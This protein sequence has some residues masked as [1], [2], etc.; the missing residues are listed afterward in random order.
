MPKPTPIEIQQKL[1][2]GLREATSDARAALKDLARARK[3]VL[4]LIDTVPERVDRE[5]GNMVKAELDNIGK[6][7]GQAIE[8]S[9]KRIERRLNNVLNIILGTPDPDQQDEKML[10]AAERTRAA[11]IAAGQHWQQT[12]VPVGM[13]KPTAIPRYERLV[14]RKDG[15]NNG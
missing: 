13:R 1:L 3:E 9:E 2:D 8:H 10:R 6:R 5:F 15:Q 12:A 11:L 7:T 14:D 4:D